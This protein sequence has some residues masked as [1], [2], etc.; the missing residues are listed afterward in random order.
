[1]PSLIPTVSSPPEPSPLDQV[2]RGQILLVSHNFPPVAGPESSLVRLNTLDLINRGWKLT[3]LTT[4]M[5]HMHQG[6]DHATLQ[7]LPPDLEVL[8]TPSYDAVLRRRFP[9]L[10]RVV[11]TLLNRWILPE[12]FLLWLPSSVPAGLRWL[13][14]NPSALI[15]SRATKHVSNITAWFLKRATGRPWIAHFSDPWLGYPMNRFQIWFGR[16]LERRIFEDADAIVTVNAQLADH[17]LHLYPSAQTKLIVIPHG[18]APLAVSPCI[19]HQESRRTLQAIHAGSFMPGLRDPNTLFDGLA[20]LNQKSR[21]AGRLTITMVGEDTIRY[22]HLIDSLGLSEVIRLHSPLPYQQCQDLVRNSD[23]LLVIDTPGFDGVFL[24]TKLIEYLPHQKPILGITERGSAVFQLLEECDFA[25]ADVK[26]PNHIAN[27]L[28]SLL[29]K[30]DTGPWG[31]TLKSLE[32]S[33]RYEISRV[34]SK[35]D[36]LISSVLA[37]K[38]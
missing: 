17:F 8:R 15:Y 34:N 32:S 27:T 24:P 19:K 35:L 36:Q 23:L 2:S 6:L 29:E 1:M 9:K 3:V 22:Q 28:E 5:E 7:G 21:L 20:L 26:D 13:K 11:L 33:K 31:S 4:T 16:I 18:F 38:I 14:A 37:K 30:W 12:I 10:A 25:F